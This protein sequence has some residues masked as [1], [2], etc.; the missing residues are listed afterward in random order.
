MH[1]E[2]NHI[3]KPFRHSSLSQ[4]IK[5]T[6][7]RTTDNYMVILTLRL[8]S[9]CTTCR[10]NQAQ[11]C[12]YRTLTLHTPLDT[13][14]EPPRHQPL[15]L[16]DT[17]KPILAVEGPEAAVSTTRRGCCGGPPPLPARSDQFFKSASQ[18]MHIC[19]G[20]PAGSHQH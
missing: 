19:I 17:D 13:T 12:L 3:C 18:T 8:L 9:A 1:E 11:S 7:A 15:P 4:V 5:Q 2:R 20:A 6:Q 16:S 10:T 14:T